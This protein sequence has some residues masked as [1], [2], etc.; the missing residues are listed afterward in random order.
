MSPWSIV[1]W[2]VTGLVIG[3]LARLIVPGRHPMGIV[4]TIVLGIVGAVVGGALYNLIAHGTVAMGEGFDVGTAW[5][6][7]IF[8][9]IGG[10]VVLWAYVAITARRGP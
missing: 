6:G 7:W 1:V 4:M 9:V 5:P 3:L 8:A 2:L 10:V